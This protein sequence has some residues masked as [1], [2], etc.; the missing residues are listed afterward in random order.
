P[1]RAKEVFDVTGAGDTVISTMTLAL[2]AKADLPTAAE[3]ANFAAG[4]VVAKIG[5]ATA[6][7]Q[8]LKNAVRQFHGMQK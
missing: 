2:A 3:I 4:I 1:T 7:P 5:T 6:S 8:E